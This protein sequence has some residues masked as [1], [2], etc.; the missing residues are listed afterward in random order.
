MRY[1][2]GPRWA[3]SGRAG[4]RVL[5][6]RRYATRWGSKSFATHGCVRVSRARARARAKSATASASSRS[7]ASSSGLA[8]TPRSLT[9]S[10]CFLVRRGPRGDGTRAIRAPIDRRV[11]FALLLLP[12]SFLYRV[13][14]GVASYRFQAHHSFLRPRG[15]RDCRQ[16]SSGL[17][18]G[19]FSGIPSSRR[20]RVCRHLVTS[21]HRSWSIAR[22]RFRFLPVRLDR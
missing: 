12:A 3:P 1:L 6:L 19:I 9:L 11:I 16:G 14:R 17:A 5:G 8:R 20:D 21:E 22:H 15:I 18:R 10:G 4:E 2:W 13:Y 7:S